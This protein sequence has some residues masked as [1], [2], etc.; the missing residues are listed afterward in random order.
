MDSGDI[1]IQD[2]DGDRVTALMHTRLALSDVDQN[3]GSL[4]ELLR[5][6]MDAAEKLTASTIGFFHFVEADQERILLQAWST[7][8]TERHCQAVGQ[9]LHYPISKAGVWVDC[10]HQRKPVMHN[11]YASLPHKKGLPDGHAALVRDLTVPI[12]RDNRVVAIL[13]V[14][15]KPSDYLPADV[16]VLQTLASLVIDMVARRRAEAALRQSQADLKRAQAVAHVGS[17]RSDVHQDALVWSEETH[18]LFGIPPGTVVTRQVFLDVVHPE[19]RAFVEQ[20]WRATRPGQPSE[21]R[22]IVDG[23][24]RWVRELAEVEL[25]ADG[26]LVGGFGTVQDIT[27]RKEAEAVLARRDRILAAAQFAADHFLRGEDWERTVCEVLAHVGQAADVSRVYVFENHAGP[28]GDRLMSQRFEWVAAGV[29]PQIDN[30]DLQALSYQGSGFGEWPARLERGECIC[31]TA[32]QQPVGVRTLLER[33]QIQAIAIMPIRVGRRWWGFIGFDECRQERR[34]LPNEIG[35]LQVVAN[36]LGAALERRQLEDKLR[37]SQKMEA[38]GQLAG[39]VA[40][41]FNNILTAFML[42]LSFMQEHPG[43]DG[44][45]RESLGQ[46]EESAKRAAALTRQLLMFSRRSVM[47]VTPVGLNEIVENM[48]KMMLRLI[49]E[50]IEL[51]IITTKDPVLI[52]ADPGM[53]DQVVVNLAVNARDAMPR[54]GRLMLTT[55]VVEIDAAR[56]Q[57]HEERRPGRFA[58]LSVQDSGCGMDEATRLRI[59]EPFFTTKGVGKG[60]G[61]GLATVYGIVAQHQGWVE[62]ESAPG[63]GS[64]FHV[65]IPELGAAPPAASP[66]ARV[67]E[68]ARGGRETI[69]LVEDD[70]SVREALAAFLRRLGYRVLECRHGLEALDVWQRQGEQVDLLYTDML[71]PEGLSGL[72]LAERL[73]VGNPALRVVLS[74]G[75]SAELADGAGLEA[76]RIAYLPKPCTPESLAHAVRACLDGCH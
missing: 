60:T 29:S 37:Q 38:I 25:D 46:L 47:R 34:W 68:A 35:A 58:C 54:G 65:F 63:Q 28:S 74:S 19:D 69:L 57:Q 51:R 21:F 75:Y 61:L 55:R 17:W 7:N 41:D 20:S 62:V 33:E 30:P 52:G 40:H 13:G 27:A 48:G 64:T 43:L 42:Q 39:G 12:M 9:G 50:H 4:D 6:A 16:T 36:M 76:R 73:R 70:R 53:L 8:T 45:M 3:G 71:M 66:A 31:A 15:N 56:A 26:R 59:F 67:A 22:I 5:V 44:E 18:R 23:Q 72:D 14:G 24:V 2:S 32:S 1:A 49:G 11:D 10:V